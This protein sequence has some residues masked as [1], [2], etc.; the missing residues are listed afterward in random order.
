MKLT[1]NGE[2]LEIEKSI[3]VREL[4]V[5]A[6]ADQPEY[7]TV[8]LNGEFVD[9]SGFDNTFVGD[10]DTVEFLYFMGGGAR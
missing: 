3:N 2:A 10:G 9:H 1:V 4:L 6:K 7:V 8:Q 5:V